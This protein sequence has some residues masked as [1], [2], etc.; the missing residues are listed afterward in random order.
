[1]KGLL[2]TVALIGICG[3]IFAAM[4]CGLMG[5]SDS[6][7]NSEGIPVGEKNDEEWVIKKYDS[8]W[9]FHYV[10]IDGHEYLLMHGAHR[11]G[12]THSPKC[13]CHLSPSEQLSD[14]R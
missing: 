3:G 8:R 12:I 7:T 14:S 10:E 6:P 13:P 4:F 1:M 9:Y 2:G 5:C 11:S